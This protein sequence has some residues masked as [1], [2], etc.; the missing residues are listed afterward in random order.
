MD[1]ATPLFPISLSLPSS[2]PHHSGSPS[3]SLGLQAQSPNTKSVLIAG[4]EEEEGSRSPRMIR[5]RILPSPSRSLTPQPPLRVTSG[6]S[7]VRQPL[8]A[9]PAT[10]PPSPGLQVV[11]APFS[12][13]AGFISTISVSHATNME[14]VERELTAEQLRLQQ[15]EQQLAELQNM[16]R[17]LYEQ[18]RVSSVR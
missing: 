8:I 5:P 2:S 18:Q 6:L 3:G 9:P 15:S 14:Q 7:P 1:L 12:V 13:P 4:E 10:F 11:P 16:L 17:D